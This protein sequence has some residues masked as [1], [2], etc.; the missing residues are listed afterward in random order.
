M[1]SKDTLPVLPR[2]PVRSLLLCWQ[3]PHAV[4]L[5][6]SG[7]FSGNAPAWVWLGLGLAPTWAVFNVRLA[8]PALRPGWA[9]FSAAFAWWAL[10]LALVFTGAAALPF[11][12]LIVA[13]FFP[14]LWA[15]LL[16]NVVL[17]R[18]LYGFWVWPVPLLAPIDPR[19]YQPRPVPLEI[20][21]RLTV[22]GALAQAPQESNA[23]WELLGLAPTQ[24]HGAIEAAYAAKKEEL[25]EQKGRLDLQAYTQAAQALTAAFDECKAGQERTV[26]ATLPSP[27]A[28]WATA[29]QSG[30]RRQ[31]VDALMLML[32]EDPREF[33]RC[34]RQFP[35]EA[36]TA[37][38]HVNGAPTP[39][40]GVL[41]GQRGVVSTLAGSGNEDFADGTGTAARFHSPQ[42]VAFDASGNV[43]VAD[44][45]NNRIRKVTPAGVVSTLAGSGNVYVADTDNH[46]IRV[47]R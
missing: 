21:E 9:H 37:W 32:L 40:F 43:Y 34:A 12:G 20:V 38:C 22:A 23:A 30:E 28:V 35:A 16:R 15:Y 44:S 10:V 45:G 33:V 8:L 6:L 41:A 1:G 39:R 24:D 11:I 25:S 42:G 46:C 29:K 18:G 27:S 5:I 17:A 3:V 31:R 2:L 14:P 19:L 7:A 47:V 4:V 26:A 13:V 36:A